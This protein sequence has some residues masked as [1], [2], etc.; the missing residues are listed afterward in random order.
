MWISKY[1][2]YFVIFSCMGWIYESIFCTVKSGSWQNRGFLYGPVCPIYGVGAATIMALVDWF[3]VQNQGQ[4]NYTWW[5]VFLVAFFGSIV[6]EYVTSWGLE[7][8]FHAY[9]WDYSDVPLNIN[10][11]VCF[12]AS[13]GFGVAG[14][15]VIYVIAP[16]TRD[17]TQW[18]TPILM[19]LFS[20][21]FMAL[22][23]VDAT[24]TVSALTGFERNVAAMEEALNQHME[25][26]VSTLQQKSQAAGEALGERKQA[27]SDRLA[28]ERLRFTRENLERL[29]KRMGGGHRA[30]L[31][32]VKGFKGY[33]TERS[34]KIRSIFHQTVKKYRKNGDQA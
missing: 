11:R 9:W 20:L 12:P 25:Q 27:A 16:A 4:V 24:L 34:A 19:E 10:G 8:L 29:T 1:F 14:L 13:V 31:N 33:G 28:E 21:I 23:S 2:V 22:L 7:K 17:A 32:R 15:L 18:I 3:T 6:L 5:Q 26:F 30:A